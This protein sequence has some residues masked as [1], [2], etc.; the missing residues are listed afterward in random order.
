MAKHNRV[1]HIVHRPPDNI[2]IAPVEKVESQHDWVLAPNER[3]RTCTVDG[4]AALVPDRALT[5]SELRAY[6]RIDPRAALFTIARGENNTRKLVRINN[7][8]L[9]G[10]VFNAPDAL[11]VLSPLTLYTARD[12][13]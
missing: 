2:R 1:D 10:G 11:A 12:H 5:G 6:L 8:T 3:M 4:V 9:V 7:A 13:A